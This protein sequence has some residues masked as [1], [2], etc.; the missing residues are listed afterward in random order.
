MRRPSRCGSTRRGASADEWLIGFGAVAGR[1]D[2]Q[3]C[4]RLVEAAA[5]LFDRLH[6]AEAAPQPRIAVAPIPDEGL[7]AAIND[8]LRRAAAPRLGASAVWLFSRAAK[9]LRSFCSLGGMTA[10]Q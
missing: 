1:R 5:S 3:R 6:E 10:R 8:R 4:G 7:G 9:L 2:A